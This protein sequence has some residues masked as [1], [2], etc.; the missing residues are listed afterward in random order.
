MKKMILFAV[1]AALPL[2][3]QPYYPEWVRTGVAGSLDTRSLAGGDFNGDGRPDI[4]VRA[5]DHSLYL[6]LT[7]AQAKPVTPVLIF[8][9]EYLNDVVTGDF[10]GDQKTDAVAADIATNS[11]IFLHSKGD[12]TF[13]APVVTPLT[14]AP[15]Q[16]AAGDFDGDGRL[17]LAI[18]SYSAGTLSIYRGDGTG[19]FA[20]ASRV[21][22]PASPSYTMAVGDIDGDHRLDVLIGRSLGFDLFFG[23]G[24]GT[25]ETPLA[26]TAKGPSVR[27]VIA[28][29][30]G[31]GDAEILSCEFGANTVTVTVNLGSRSFAAPVTYDT[32][33]GNPYDLIVADVNG[34]GKPD[35]VASL[36]NGQVLAAFAGNGNGSLGKPDYAF[37]PTASNSNFFPG[38]LLAADYNGDGQTD[39]AVNS[40]AARG[41]AIFAN[42]AGNVAM[43]VSSPYPVISAG[44]PI[45]FGIIVSPDKGYIPS[46]SFPAPF[47]TGTV[48]LK[49]GSASLGTAVPKNRLAAIG[50]A[51]FSAG[52]HTLTAEF[53]GDGSYRAGVSPKFDQK[54][55]AEKTI[56]TLKSNAEGSVPPPYG[57]EFFLTA[58]VQ[59][60]IAGSMYGS[61]W[62]FIDGVRQ[63]Y[64]LSGPPM[65]WSVNFLTPGTHTFYV[66]YEGNSTQP[67]SVSNVVTQVIRKAQSIT[68]IDFGSFQTQVGKPLQTRVSLD[69]NPHAGTPGGWVT[70]FEGTKMLAKVFGDNRYF[71]GGLSLYLELPPFFQIGTHLIHAE[72]DGD[73]NYEPSVSKDVTVVVTAAPPA[74]PRRHSTH[75]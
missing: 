38:H 5:G 3:A 63:E 16:L 27:F 53:A 41:I 8:T 34:D 68:T 9:S 60:P 42:A 54:V 58:D 51:S 55:V 15:T 7:D 6:V 19:H 48:T 62:R 23:K 47:P 26:F 46:Y 50:V 71:S 52:T 44:Q 69:E 67:P 43:T 66:R 31:D 18:R 61:F 24:D 64:T 74:L 4:L 35:V 57:Q 70:I 25:F 37:T 11:L 65:N 2:S 30:D 45:T 72:Y 21:T 56:T 33:G 59:S 75:H 40:L 32:G 14:F 12:G 29:L 10:D 17:D 49:E 28:D 39:I 36:A 22:L 73:Q 13:D 1:L 20:E